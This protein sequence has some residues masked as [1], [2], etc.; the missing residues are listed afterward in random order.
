[1]TLSDWRNTRA[2]YLLRDIDFRPTDWICDDDMTDE[3]KKDHPEYEA[4]G[5]YLKENDTIDCC[6][7]WWNELSADNR[8]IIQ[9][10][11]NFDAEKFYKI[12]GVRV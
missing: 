10:I 5:G 11:E 9:N 7:D 2:Y 8:C 12:T 4:T 1:M 3:E 6:I